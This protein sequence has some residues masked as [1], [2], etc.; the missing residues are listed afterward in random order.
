[1][2]VSSPIGDLPLQMNRMRLTRRGLVV[3][4]SMGAWP[5]RIEVSPKDAPELARFLAAPL[6]VAASGA[7]VLTAIYSRRSTHNE[8]GR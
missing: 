4:A 2:K 3:D 1:M 7:V 6:L 8:G 5:A